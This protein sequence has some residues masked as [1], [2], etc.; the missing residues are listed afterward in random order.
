MCGICGY[1]DFHHNLTKEKE[2][3]ATIL[4]QM[5]NTLIHRGPDE[6]GAVVDEHIAFAHRR[7]SVVDI[8]HG[9]QPMTIRYGDYDYHIVY[10]GELYNTKDIQSALRQKGYK[11][12]SQSDTEAVLMSYIA[13]GTDMLSMLEGI[14]SFAIWDGRLKQVLFCRDRLGVKPLFYMHFQGKYLFASEIKALYAY[15]NN[16]PAITPYGLCEIFGLGPARTPG[17]GVFKEV[18]EIPPAH[19]A[20]IN[21]SGMQLFRYWQLPA[22]QHE[23]SY[24]KTVEEIRTRLFSAIERQLVSDVPI[25]TLL[26]GGLDSSIISSV[27]AQYMKEHHR[28]LSTYSFDFTENDKYFQSSNFQPDQ[29][30][31]FVEEMVTYLGTNHTYL[32]CD[33]ENLYRCLYDAVDAKDLP[34]MADVD[35]SMLY[36]TS[37]I[38]PHHTVCLSGECADELFF[39]YPWFYAEESYEKDEFPWSRNFS[40]RE[41]LLRPGLLP[42][43]NML[44]KYVKCQYDNTI[45]AVP[46][47]QKKPA[48]PNVPEN[49]AILTLCGLCRHY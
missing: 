28:T 23:D 45:Q 19:A 44:A 48:A 11:L 1:I 47:I 25:C 20:I 26:S 22:Y 15:P 24:E 7:L 16:R 31:P 2:Y 18:H 36:F 46:G 6:E 42:E 29:D 32:K 4:Q 49:S 35:S 38:K 41:Q 13:F 3:H 37:L 12:T 30:R 27:A 17:C 34:G 5:R 43:E 40:I 10:N 39:G 14:Y 9:K 21:Y 8:L 33:N